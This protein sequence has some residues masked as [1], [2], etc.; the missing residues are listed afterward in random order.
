[1]L[2]STAAESTARTQTDFPVVKGYSNAIAV[3]AALTEPYVPFERAP[4]I[5]SIIS[6]FVRWNESALDKHNTP[7]AFEQLQA[8]DI[9]YIDSVKLHDVNWKGTPLKKKPALCFQRR[10]S[11]EYG[12][13]THT[14]LETPFITAKQRAHI[15]S[16]F[17]VADYPHAEVLR[18]Q[19]HRKQSNVNSIVV[20]ER[21]STVS[22]WLTHYLMRSSAKSGDEV[23]YG[24]G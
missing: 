15:Q 23:K 16:M 22:M 5:Q 13:V 14:L 9:A 3:H 8:E 2:K 24:N 11:N 4:E 18:I 10:E 20:I 1:M 6:L 17:P 21:D 12:S 7:N 19:L